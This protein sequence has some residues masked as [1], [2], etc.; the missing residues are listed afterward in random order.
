[1][2]KPEIH[3]LSSAKKFGGVPEDYVEIHKLMDSSKGAIADNRHRCLTHNAW[4][5]SEIL[6]RIK[7]HNSTDCK[8]DGR[9][10]TIKNSA[11]KEIS[12]REIGEQHVLEDFGMK[13]I[14]SAQDYI[15]EMEMKAWMNNGRGDVPSSFKK[16]EENK[17]V[18]KILLNRD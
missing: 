16:I 8:P 13:F 11:G 12:V 10:Y 1:M 3:A 14:P 15:Q 5:I 17:V 18:K 9:F 4:F 6:E 7:F 2:A